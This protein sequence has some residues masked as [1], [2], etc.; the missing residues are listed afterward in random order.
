MKIL[1]IAIG[2][3]GDVEPFLAIGQMLN[4]AGHDTLCVFP[5][6]YRK[7]A[8][9]S[10]IEFA[11]LGHEFIDL[12]ESDIGKKAIGAAGKGLNK[13]R[14]YIEL[15]RKS[16]PINRQMIHRQRRIIDNY[17]PDRILYHAKS[18]YPLIWS[19]SNPGKATM[20]SAVPYLHFTKK[21]AHLA[22]NGNYGVLINRFSYW[23]AQFGLVSTTMQSVKWLNLAKEIKRS[24]IRYVLKT[25]TCIYTVSPTLMPRPSDWPDNIRILGHYDRRSTSA[26]PLPEKVSGF[27][28]RHGK[29]LFVTFGSMTNPDPEGK[30]RMI[31]DILTRHEIPAIINTAAGGLIEPAEY[32]TELIHFTRSVPYSALFPHLYGVIHHGGSGT[33]HLGLKNGCATMIIPH[34]IDQFAWNDFVA[35][36][37]AGPKGPRIDGIQE[38]D[39][40]SHILDL[41]Q[42]DDYRNRAVEVSRKMAH[43]DFR[44]EIFQIIAPQTS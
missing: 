44:H 4:H 29:V 6:Q 11:S 1:L 43:E 23:I 35:S 38:R 17:A 24:Q 33:T 36:L 5:E 42:N 27:V 25:N 34:I 37:G 41:F 21:R 16:I 12:L 26:S 14:A 9:E 32:D 18:V 15:G 31:V 7:L 30:T 40:E 22:F 19:V 3:Q 10:E 20:L 39:L 8:D 2:T 28:H 13:V